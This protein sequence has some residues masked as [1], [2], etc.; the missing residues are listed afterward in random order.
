MSPLSEASAVGIIITHA[1]PG[2]ALN[3][4][5][6]GIWI[7]RDGG[8]KWKDV[9]KI[10]SSSSYCY[11]LQKCDHVKVFACLYVQAFCFNKLLTPHIGKTSQIRTKAKRVL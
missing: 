8:Y 9:R 10:M 5:N 1:N 7:S 6:I 4:K 11:N 3:K 2:Y